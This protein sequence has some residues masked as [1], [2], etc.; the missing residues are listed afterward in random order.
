MGRP[1]T[2]VV[3]ISRQ[4]ASGGSYIGQTLAARLGLRYTDREI[5]EQAAD[6]A[7][8]SAADLARA[9]ERADGFWSFFLRTYGGGGPDAPYLPPTVPVVYGDDLFELQSTI[10]RD[11]AGRFD[12]VVVGRCGFH[13]LADHPGLISVRVHADEV[14]RMR[15][16]MDI[17]GIA[18]EGAARDLIRRSDAQRARFVRTFT[19][20]DWDDAC[21][22]H[23]CVDTSAVGLELATELVL[24]LVSARLGRRPSDRAGEEAPART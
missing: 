17:Y 13:V 4:L 3:T 20:R 16:A 24:E 21:V 10:I 22:H 14:W 5:L 7:G 1:T 19:G 11:V 8:V 9:E 12:A 15:R 2:T 23:L 6:K 18:D